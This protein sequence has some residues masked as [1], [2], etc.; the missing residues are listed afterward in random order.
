MISKLGT[1]KIV[2]G[3]DS[4]LIFCLGSHPAMCDNSAAC[5]TDIRNT[6][7]VLD[8]PDTK[9]CTQKGDSCNCTVG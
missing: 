2:D 7:P 6:C 5:P 9:L 3:N 8:G 1:N 4:I